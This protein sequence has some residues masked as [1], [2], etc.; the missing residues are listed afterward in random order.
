MTRLERKDIA[1]GFGLVGL[2]TALALVAFGDTRI[3]NDTWTGQIGVVIIAGPSAWLAGFVFGG[4]FGQPRAEGWALAL[5]GAC[6]STA[7]GAAIAGNIVFPIFGTIMAPA[8]L[9]ESAI[10][11]PMIA[12]VW[13]MHMTGLHFILL[14]S[15]E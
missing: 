12:V 1:L 3:L 2:V 6:L 14:N 13:L 10:A 11:Y 4:M 15:D 5:M 7:L 8:A 9:L